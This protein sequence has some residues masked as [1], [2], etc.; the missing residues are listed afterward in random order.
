M[1]VDADAVRE[2]GASD[3]E[4]AVVA[5]GT[6]VEAGILATYVLVDLNPADVGQGDHRIVRRDP[7]TRRAH[8][9]VFP[10]RDMGIRVAH[11]LT[12]RTIDYLPT[13]N[14]TRILRSSRPPCPKRLQARRSPRPR[15]AAG[16]V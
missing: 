15:S 16:R 3:F 10:E 6:A 14:S 8:R 2:L 9:V 5:I 11:T 7:G 1:G 12:G 4:T 13:E